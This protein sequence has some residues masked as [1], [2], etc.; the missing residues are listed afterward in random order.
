[1]AENGSAARKTDTDRGSTENT[2]G[3]TISLLPAAATHTYTIALM[4]SDQSRKMQK[5]FN[6]VEG[7]SIERKG[8]IRPLRLSNI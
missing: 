8:E 6:A 7:K 3:R 2:N 1:L 5:R 4:E